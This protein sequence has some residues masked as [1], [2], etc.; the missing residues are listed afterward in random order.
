MNTKLI[1]EFKCE[2]KRQMFTMLSSQLSGLFN[3]QS[4]RD[5][6][7]IGN[8]NIGSFFFD[9]I[10]F[11]N[12]DV[13]VVEFKKNAA[14]AIYINDSGWISAGVSICAGNHG[15]INPWEQIKEKRNILYGIF[16]KRG[17]HKMFIKTIILFEKPFS[18]VRGITSFNFENHRW[19]LMADTQD[20]AHIVRQ[21]C[22]S[23]APIDFLYKTTSALIM[24]DTKTKKSIVRNILH[25]FRKWW[26]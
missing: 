2:F 16:K 6:T 23:S 4:C 19:F 3:S 10:L 22:S 25:I 18:L 26:R 5:F 14:G 13:F 1:G 8:L 17:F 11:T 20:I 21:N 15:A 24:C 7:L 12:T 9:A